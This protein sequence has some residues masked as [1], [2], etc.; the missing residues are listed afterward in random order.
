M[1]KV[2]WGVPG[3]AE[4]GGR[5]E[6]KH[7]KEPVRL[8]DRKQDKGETPEQQLFGLLFS[9]KESDQLHWETTRIT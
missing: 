8:G 6:V 3:Q 2:D 1:I 5:G 4:T 9:R 7:A